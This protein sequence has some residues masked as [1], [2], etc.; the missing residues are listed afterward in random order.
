MN[1][2]K[3]LFAFAGENNQMTNAVKELTSAGMAA[4]PITGTIASANSLAAGSQNSSTI[5][6]NQTLTGEEKS[7]WQ[8]VK[9]N[10]WECWAKT[11]KPVKVFGEMALFFMPVVIGGRI[12]YVNKFK[13]R[14][15]FFIDCAELM[16][17]LEKIKNKPRHTELDRMLIALIWAMSGYL[18][19]GQSCEGLF[20]SNRFI[21]I[22]F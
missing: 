12:F 7:T 3:K 10:F 5:V 15:D 13:P 14:A 11:P 17:R 6:E 18:V 19:L 8:A 1:F 21:T 9:E 4:M 20:G 22:K 2:L 16:D